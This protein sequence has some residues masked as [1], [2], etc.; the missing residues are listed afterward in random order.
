MKKISG[1]LFLIIIS[2]VLLCCKNISESLVS[3]EPFQIVDNKL[4]VIVTSDFNNLRSAIPSALPSGIVYFGKLTGKDTYIKNSGTN[5]NLNFIFDPYTSDTQVTLI[6]YA[7][8]NGTESLTTATINSCAIA[9]GTSTQINIKEKQLT[10]DFGTINLILNSSITGNGIVELDFTLDTGLDPSCVI[11]C[12]GENVS[13]KFNLSSNGEQCSLG[14]ATGVTGIP[15][16][17]Y[18]LTFS[19]TDSDNK[20]VELENPVQIINV[21]TG[22]T[23]NK[24]L[25]NG[26]LVDELAIKKASYTTFYVC[27]ESNLSF[28]GTEGASGL[29]VSGRLLNSGSLM[30]PKATVAQAV[31]L[32]T[33]TTKS[34]TIYVD[35]TTNE[36]SG[37]TINANTTIK[38]LG[39][40]ATIQRGT[41]NSGSMITVSSG[42]E[43]SFE[44]IVIDGNQYDKSTNTFLNPTNSNGAGI[45]NKGTLTLSDCVVQYCNAGS[46]EGGGIYTESTLILTGTTKIQYNKAKTGGGIRFNLSNSSLKSTIGK[47]SQDNGIKICNNTATE[48][49]GGVKL[50]GQSRVE[51]NA[52]QIC[53]NSTT[54]K[55]SGVYIWGNGTYIAKF[56]MNGGSIHNNESGYGGGVYIDDGG[57]KSS[58]IMDSGTIYSNTATQYGKAI[59]H[60][61]GSSDNSQI[62]ISGN[63]Y[64]NEDN[65][66]YLGSGKVITV[67]G[68]LTPTDN[69]TSSGT[70]KTYT[71]TITPNTYPAT[72]SDAVTVLDVEGEV[73]LSSQSSKFQVKENG[74]GNYIIKTDGKIYK[75]I[76]SIDALNAEISNGQTEIE[77][78]SNI[79]SSNG[80]IDISGASD[81]II[82]INAQS[83]Y[84]L[85]I[86]GSDNLT[87]KY[88]NFN[89]GYGST[90]GGGV[91]KKS[92]GEILIENCTFTNCKNY[93]RHGGN[94]NGGTLYL[95]AA[96]K[97]TIKNCN[98][99][100]DNTIEQA[101]SGGFIYIA[102]DCSN[103]TIEGCEFN[104]GFASHGG[105]LSLRTSATVSNC[106][107]T[108]NKADYAGGAINIGDVANVSIDSCTF[109]GNS[110]SKGVIYSCGE[111]AT[112][113][114]TNCTG[115]Y[116]SEHE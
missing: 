114:I 68:N 32:C 82:T 88:V 8:L 110:T 85:D 47:D 35:G 87:L 7:C 95:A 14:L 67:T 10:A 94:G 38:K 40:G 43:V 16:G 23:T 111:R 108:D 31:A 109:S 65:D 48:C 34:Y 1:F 30:K 101:E 66:V 96:T 51:M 60:S 115:S 6:V 107:F 44:N 54:G 42:A 3:E 116:E 19:A 80:A 53:N 77:I 74:S 46:G 2:V 102:D 76:D 59:C 69:G 98:F 84:H 90:S 55:G 78:A 79:T 22:M 56:T 106:T 75:L 104:G 100:N 29:D 61:V 18:I 21:A 83:A 63:A 17:V 37:I 50:D 93:G 89:G 113:T 5:T 71:A 99:Y 15:A 73:S 62:Q 81:S 91:I 24:W 103:V 45:V 86:S 36:S 12:N 57:C 33:D 112:A 49:G 13:S 11:T 9:I 64:I 39:T 20:T 26:E 28:Y 70:A 105:A 72:S 4:S 92:G 97:V 58:F 41:G 52:G 25:V 27:G